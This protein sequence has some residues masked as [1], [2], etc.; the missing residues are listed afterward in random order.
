[1]S[2]KWIVF[3]SFLLLV[4]PAWSI[5][6][7]IVTA[8]EAIVYSDRFM[9]APIG[10]IG[11]GKRIRIGSK[12]Q[13]RGQVYPI[14]V[15]G[16]IAYIAQVDITI[17]DGSKVE[18]PVGSDSL[19][20]L[21][22]NKRGFIFMLGQ[23]SA[24]WKTGNFDPSGTPRQN[25]PIGLA[26]FQLLFH[27]K[28][29]QR[30]FFRAGIDYQSATKSNEKLVI[31]SLMTS[32][33]YRV[34][35]GELLKV[36]LGSALGAS[37]FATYQADPFFKLDGFSIQLDLFS[38]FNYFISEQFFLNFQLGHRS[39]KLTGFAMPNQYASFSPLFSGVYYLF[40]LAF[41]Y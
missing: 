28:K 6:D 24:N 18:L 25:D 5:S 17:L 15:S 20:G 34:W 27:Y 33:V 16:K 2:Y 35:Q 14:V 40:G 3:F 12:P 4:K 22:L 31:P 23:F 1:L 10:K 30:T 21:D 8:K 7:A 9:Q 29:S 37:N 38:E 13:N 41:T 26:N 19:K 39:Q 11:Q 36:N 32:L